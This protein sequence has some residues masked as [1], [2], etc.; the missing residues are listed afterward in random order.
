MR[1]DRNFLGNFRL[2]LI[3]LFR[4]EII[5]RKKSAGETAILACQ[6]GMPKWQVKMAGTPTRGMSEWHA[7]LAV[8]KRVWQSVAL[9]FHRSQSGGCGFLQI[10]IKDFSRFGMIFCG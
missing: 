3:G 5:D 1:G 4:G 8:P 6:N 7:I 2:G 9:I 10:L